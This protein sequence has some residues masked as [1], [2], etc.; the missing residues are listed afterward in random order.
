V[1]C[2]R[3]CDAPDTLQFVSTFAAVLPAPAVTSHRFLD[4]G[5]MPVVPAVELSRASVPTS[6]PPRVR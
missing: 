3:Q 4:L 6:P 2:R 5:T 1:S